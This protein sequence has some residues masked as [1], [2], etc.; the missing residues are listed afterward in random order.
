MFK[1]KLKQ[2]IESKLTEDGLFET[3]VKGVR[4]FRVTEG[5]RCSPAIYEPAVIAIVSCTKE[6]IVD[7]KS[8]VYVAEQYMC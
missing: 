4:L 2:L 8:Y 3:G 5:V 7:G 6:A 1:Q